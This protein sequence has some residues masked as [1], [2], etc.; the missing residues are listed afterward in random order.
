MM[1]EY[2]FMANTFFLF[3]D[4][5]TDSTITA[6]HEKDTAVAI[7]HNRIN[8]TTDDQFPVLGNSLLIDR[9]S[10]HFSVKSSCVDLVLVGINRVYNHLVA[11]LE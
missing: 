2:P 10:S 6:A 11:V 3:E 7:S 9:P 4:D 5:L 8:T 1:L